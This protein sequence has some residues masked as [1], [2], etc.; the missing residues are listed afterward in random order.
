MPTT[1]TEVSRLK[2][3]HPDLG[4][5]GGVGLHTE[6]RNAWTKI[7]DNLNSRFFIKDAFANTSDLIINHNFKCSFDE[8]QI[9]LYL[10]N[11][12]D[13]ELTRIDSGSS[14]S[15]AD[16]PTFATPS[17]ETTNITIT[18]ST[19][20][21]QDI[22]V[23]VLHNGGGS[24]GGGGGGSLLWTQVAGAAPIEDLEFN[25][26][27][28]FFS[29]GASQEIATYIKVPQ[30]Y[31]LGTPIKMHVSAYSPNDTDE[32]RI[33]T[34]STLLRNGIDAINNS[35]N[36]KISDSGDVVNTLAY[37]YRELSLDISDSAGKINNVAISAGDLIKVEL[38]R[39]APSGTEDIE[40]L[41]VIGSSTEVTFS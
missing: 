1:S 23:V 25:N 15:I 14:P 5:D 4:Y 26:N 19:G 9:I 36:Q 10:R 11:I 16:F 13:G 34:T 33:Q 31:E 17:T 40:E 41:R 20:A 35:L 21:D 24:A 7:G 39:I 32:W 29:Q 37:V 3:S 18:N 38:T 22:A 30:S 2:L 8:L 6:V 28:Y 12:A 27:V